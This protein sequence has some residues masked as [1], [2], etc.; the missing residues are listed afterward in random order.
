MTG[1]LPETEIPKPGI[2]KSGI[3]KIGVPKTGIPKIGIP[4]TGIPKLG[5]PEMGRSRV[6][7][8][9]TPPEPPS[10]ASSPNPS[11]F[12]GWTFQDESLIKGEERSHFLAN[13]QGPF[14]R[15]VPVT[16]TPS[17]FPKVL[18]YKWG[19]YCRTNGRRT[20]STNGRRRI[21]EFPFLRSLEARKAWRYKWGGT[22]VQ[23]GGVLPYFSD[24]LYGLGFPKHC[25]VW[26][27]F[28]QKVTMVR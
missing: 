22:A 11:R 12:S 23:I 25:P 20:C 13:E 28:G 16:Q 17:I 1:S 14:V 9:Q 18:L 26:A 7:L 21:A 5:I 6:P 8:I 19:T 15:I 3:P 27:T 24:K 10:D 2:P 4:K